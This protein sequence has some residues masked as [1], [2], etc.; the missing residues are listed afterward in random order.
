MNKKISTTSKFFEKRGMVLFNT[1]EKQ[2]QMIDILINCIY[3]K[4]RWFF[5]ELWKATW[6]QDQVYELFCY[7]IG[8]LKARFTFL[9]SIFNNMI[10]E[11]IMAETHLICFI[12][13]FQEDISEKIDIILLILKGSLFISKQQYYN[14]FL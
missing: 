9:M 11:K 8:I 2:M 13:M 7:E 4:F 6:L 3:L 10:K 1:T 14:S 5:D 12:Q